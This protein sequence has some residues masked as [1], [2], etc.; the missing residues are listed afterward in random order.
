MSDE[1][2]G[3]ASLLTPLSFDD[4]LRLAKAAYDLGQVRGVV[5]ALVRVDVE[6]RRQAIATLLPSLEAIA[7]RARENGD[8]VTSVLVER[9]LSLARGGMD[10]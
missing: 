10:A 7:S 1:G 2:N 3:P 8:A 5:S 9:A 6:S 4:A